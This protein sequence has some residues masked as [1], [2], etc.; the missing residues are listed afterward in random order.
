MNALPETPYH[1]LGFNFIWLWQAR[2]QSRFSDLIRRAFIGSEN[3]IALHF[4]NDD[5]RF[6]M[7][8]SK[9]VAGMRMKLDIKPV[10][11]LIRNTPEERLQIAFNFEKQVAGEDIKDQIVQLLDQWN[12]MKN[13]ASSIETNLETGLEV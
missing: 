13:E 9:D 11:I 12:P 4:S 7:Y 10:R 6:G 8:M 2:E 5:A 3:P 1:T